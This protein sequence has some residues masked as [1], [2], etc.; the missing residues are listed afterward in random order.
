MALPGPAVKTIAAIE[1]R[2]DDHPGAFARAVAALPLD[3]LADHFMAHDQGVADSNVAGINFS[4]R[5]ANTRMRYPDQSL[6][7]LELWHFD[8]ANCD[9]RRRF[10]YHCLHGVD[11]LGG[12]TVGASTQWLSGGSP[13]DREKLKLRGPA[14]H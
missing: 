9:L 4:I 3:D 10:E 7:G 8:I 11:V 13:F 12:Q 5:T 1:A 14:R 2:I 6:A